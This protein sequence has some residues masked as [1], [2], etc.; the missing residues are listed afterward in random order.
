M[1]SLHFASCTRGRKEDTDLYRSLI[2]LGKGTFQFFENNKV[3]VSSRYNEVLEDRAGRNEIL[4]FAHDD[5]TITDTFIAEKLNAAISRYGFAIIG[6]AGS[7]VLDV[8]PANR[9]TSW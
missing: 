2:A 5:L 1:K 7:S 4:V 3:G 9:P 6:V 8:A